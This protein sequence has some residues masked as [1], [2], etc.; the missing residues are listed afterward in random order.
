MYT[1]GTGRSIAVGTTGGAAATRLPQTGQD[2]LALALI[3]LALVIV[4]FVLLRARL[5]ARAARL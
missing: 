4:G 3:G 5:K 1:S 2:L